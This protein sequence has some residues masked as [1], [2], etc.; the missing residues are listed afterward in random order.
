MQLCADGGG[1]AADHYDQLEGALITIGGWWW[2]WSEGGIQERDVLTLKGLKT[3]RKS[4][5][6][7]NLP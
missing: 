1:A 5:I 3:Q 4:Q 6:F 7:P 2:W